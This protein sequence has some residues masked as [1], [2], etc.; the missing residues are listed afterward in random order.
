MIS[1]SATDL[2]RA[3][4]DEIARAFNIPGVIRTVALDISA[5]FVFF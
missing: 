5:F 2:L 3:A 4:T 1:C